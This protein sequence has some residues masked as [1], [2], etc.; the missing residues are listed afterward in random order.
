MPALEAL[1]EHGACNTIAYLLEY[2]DFTDGACAQGELEEA[3]AIRQRVLTTIC[4]TPPP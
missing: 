1:I 4:D 2:I 3:M